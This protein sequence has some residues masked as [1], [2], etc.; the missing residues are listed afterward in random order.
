MPR[1]KILKECGFQQWHITFSEFKRDL[2]KDRYLTPKDRRRLTE[3]LKRGEWVS[4]AG[5]WYRIQAEGK[6]EK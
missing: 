3:S 6:A 4:N 1:I 5:S 2:A